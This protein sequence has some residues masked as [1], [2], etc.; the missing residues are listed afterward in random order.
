LI[1]AD[2]ELLGSDVYSFELIS[3]VPEPSAGLLL[4]AGAVRLTLLRR[5][6][7]RT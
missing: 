7:T 2:D 6:K 1:G 3:A 4:A 5:W